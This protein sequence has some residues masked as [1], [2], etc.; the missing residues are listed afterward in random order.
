MRLFLL[1]LLLCT[2]LPLLAAGWDGQPNR[3]RV[4]VDAQA[5]RAVVE[6][7][8]WQQS[9]TLSMYNVMQVPSLPN[10][11]ASLVEGLLATDA[12][13][14]ALPLKDLGEGDFGIAGGQRIRVSYTVRLDVRLP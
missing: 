14:S 13:G 10:G 3:Y 9:D 4:H 6:A 1:S 8:L 11:Q 7:D 5:A 2:P 12:T